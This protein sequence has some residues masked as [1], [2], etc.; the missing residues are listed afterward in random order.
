[1]VAHNFRIQRGFLSHKVQLYYQFQACGP[2]TYSIPLLF[3]KS[4]ISLTFQHQF[5]FTDLIKNVQ[6]YNL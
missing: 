4:T 1:M 6:H 2:I 5:S 3:E